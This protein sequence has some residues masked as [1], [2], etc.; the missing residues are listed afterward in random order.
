M[1]TEGKL[2][3][4]LVFDLNDHI[5]SLEFILCFYV[6]PEWKVMVSSLQ[7]FT[8]QVTHRYFAYSCLSHDS[9]YI[10]CCL[11]MLSISAAQSVHSN[12]S[13]KN[14]R[15]KIPLF[16]KPHHERTVSQ[17]GLDPLTHLCNL[18]VFV[19]F[20]QSICCKWITNNKK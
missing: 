5:H 13:A 16:W 11:S 18:L 6:P 7:K 2:V 3:Y 19:D 20:I 8:S 15:A 10:L 17:K 9:L 4:F 1:F 12:Y 14:S